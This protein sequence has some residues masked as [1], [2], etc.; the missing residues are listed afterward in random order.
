LKRSASGNET[1]PEVPPPLDAQE[2]AST[3]SAE[4]E[5]MLGGNGLSDLEMESEEGP[6][7]F[8]QDD[9]VLQQLTRSRVSDEIEHIDGCLRAS[10]A[11]GQKA[12]TLHVAFC[13]PFARVPEIQAEQLEGPECRIKLV[14]CQP[15]GA[16]FDLKLVQET[17]EDDGRVQIIFFAEG[18]VL[19]DGV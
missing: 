18:P 4:R 6:D 1:V 15:Y 10:F 13:P 5:A 7:L 12:L 19:S 11:P 17:S 2:L 3:L 8:G 14:Q 16:R 9:N